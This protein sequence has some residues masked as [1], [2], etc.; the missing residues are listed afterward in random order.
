MGRKPSLSKVPIL[1]EPW[2][3][4]WLPMNRLELSQGH[5]TC[6][7]AT[8]GPL[9]A[10]AYPILAALVEALETAAAELA[11]VLEPDE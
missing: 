8:E 3:R 1:G 7:I 9:P 6:H 2:K 11:E 5:I 10:A 4:E